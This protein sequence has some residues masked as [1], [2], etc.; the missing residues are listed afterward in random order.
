MNTSNHY[1]G[2]K[3]LNAGENV[4]LQYLTAIK[5]RHRRAEPRHSLYLGPLGWILVRTPKNGRRSACQPPNM[6][7]VENSDPAP[8]G[9]IGEFSILVLPPWIRI[10][11]WTHSVT[12]IVV[13]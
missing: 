10:E 13:R 11:K 7:K 12:G 4:E 3:V 9:A 8:L 1:G 5:L 6:G 2:S